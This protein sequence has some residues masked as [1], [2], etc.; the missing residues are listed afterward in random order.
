MTS[1]SHTH[2]LSTSTRPGPRIGPAAAPDVLKRA[3]AA[4]WAALEAVGAARGR[5]EL[6]QLAREHE[7]MRPEFAATLRDAARRGWL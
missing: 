7:A 3:F 6:L 1:S 5:R 2:T 4:L